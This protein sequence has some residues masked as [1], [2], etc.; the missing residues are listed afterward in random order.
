MLEL[1][2]DDPRMQKRLAPNFQRWEFACLCGCG[3]ADIDQ[4]TVDWCQRIRDFLDRPVVVIN[5]CRCPAYN[6]K[7]RGFARSYHMRCM[8]A[9]IAVH[10]VDAE[11][12]Q[13]LLDEWGVP[14]LGR[15][16]DFT[17]L[18]VRDGRA[19]W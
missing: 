6:R 10:Q 16:F 18:D 12:V 2:R 17:H 9:D 7:V 14:G 1:Y 3:L 11:T 13:E 4:R 8:A 19:R 15:Y 5:G